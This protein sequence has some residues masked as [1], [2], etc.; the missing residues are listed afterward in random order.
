MTKQII[1]TI[2]YISFFLFGTYI[3]YWA[4]DNHGFERGYK[5]GVST[6]RAMEKQGK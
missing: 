2:I 1:E 6:G 4:G 3:A 5:R